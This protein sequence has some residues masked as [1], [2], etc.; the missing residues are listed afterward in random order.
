MERWHWYGHSAIVYN[1]GMGGVGKKGRQGRGLIRDSH[2]RWVKDY[3][4][5]IGA[6]TSIN[7]E[8]WALING[9]RLSSKMGITH[10]AVELDAK[11]IVDL[12]L[13]RK[14]PNNSYTSLLNDCKYLLNQ[15]Q[16]TKIRHVYR[17]A[18]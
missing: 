9:L 15:F 12:V 8:F 16:R 5:Y 10:F 17:E 18:N 7:A 4:K 6:T 1:L 14:T 2:G 11:V 3:M 13:S